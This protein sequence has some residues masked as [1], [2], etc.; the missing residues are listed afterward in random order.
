LR[1]LQLRLTLLAGHNQLRLE[2]G[3]WV[4][5]GSPDFG[6]NPTIVDHTSGSANNYTWVDQSVTDAGVILQSPI[7]DATALTTPYLSF[8]IMSH[9]N[10]GSVTTFNEIH[11]EASDGVGGWVPVDVISGD[12]GFQ[13]VEFGY[14]V[15]GLTYGANLLQF[16]FRAESGGDS[17]DYDNDMLLD[18]VGVSEMPTCP[19]P[20]GLAAYNFTST[21]ADFD[22]TENGT[23]T[24]WFIEYGPVGFT[25][26][27]GTSVA[28]G[29]NTG[30]NLTGLT[31]NTFYEGYVRSF[32]SVGDTSAYHGPVSFNTYDVAPFTFMGWDN[33]C[34]TLGF[35][36]IS[37]TGTDLG[38]TDDG[39]AGVTLDY[40]FIYQGTIITEMTVGNN[41][42]IDLGTLTGAVGYGG[43][44]NTLDDGIH[45]WGDDLDEE[46]G[47][48]YY[49]VVGTAPNRITIVQWDNI[50]NFSG[51]IGD[52]TVTFQVQIFETTNEI[53]F[54]YD[55]VV[56]GGTDAA[57]DYAA[58][59]D[60]GAAGPVTD[61]NISNNDPTFLTNNSCVRFYYP[62]CPAPTAL[63][64]VG[65]ADNDSI[66]FSWAAG[67]TETEWLI[68]YGPEGFTPGTGTT[69]T[70]FTTQ[71]TIGG[72]SGLTTYDIYVQA[73][74]AV[75]DSSTFHGPLSASTE[76]NPLNCVASTATTLLVEDFEGAF[77]A[78]WSQVATADPDWTWDG[79]GGTGSTNTGPSGA[80]SGTGFLYLETSGGA[81]G[82]TDTLFAPSVNLTSTVGDARA[83]WKYHMYGDD[84]GK[85]GFEVSTDGVLW[86]EVWSDSGQLQLDELD[87]W[88]TASA[89]LTPYA[90][91]IVQMRFVG[92][93]AGTFNGDMAI[94]TFAVEA[95]ISCQQPTGLAVSN[96]T[97]NTVDLIW[98]PGGLESS[99]IIEYGPAGFTP[100]TGTQVTTGNNPE[101]VTG[102][103]DNTNY[104]FYVYA[105][106]GGGDISIPDGP[107]NTN[108]LIA[109]PAPSGLTITYGSND[110]VA[111]TWTPGGLEAAWIIE[112]G[113][114]GFTPGTGTAQGSTN[115]PDTITGLA[116]GVYEFYVQAD[117][118]SGVNNPWDG[119]VVYATPI[120]NDSTCNSINVPVDGSTTNYVN[121]NGTT[122]VGETTAGF[123][124]VWFDFIAPASGHVE[125]RTCGTDFDNMLEVFTTTDCSDFGTFT[126]IVATNSNPFTTCNGVDP[127]GVNLCGLTPGAKYYLAIGSEVDGVTGIFPLTLTEL[128]AINAGTATPA[129]AC[130]A[131][132]AFDLFNSISG[133]LTTTG[134]WYNPTVAPGN[135]IPSTI[136]A[137][138]VPVGTYPMFYV[139]EEICGSDTVETSITVVAAPNV[140]TGSTV[141]AGCNFN[142]VALT[143]GLSGTI[144]LGG[145]WYDDA[146]NPLTG[147]LVTF[148]GEPA[149]NY[150]YH[151]VVDN[152]VC[153]ADS[154]TV[155]VTIIDCVGLEENNLVMNVYPNPVHDQLNIQM[156]NYT[157]TTTI[158]VYDLAGKRMN[159]VYTVSGNIIKLDVEDYADGVYLLKLTS[160]G[161]T[162]EIRVVK[163]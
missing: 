54:V 133:N 109:C 65:A 41:G 97:I 112:Y 87:P 71:D 132:A 114:L 26:G 11:V 119:P 3:P 30:F 110:T 75:G 130:E 145:T 152:G 49:E 100:G 1:R 135:E 107:V 137:V 90:G 68:E 37:G 153:A 20:N 61:F 118:G 124:T 80:Y 102:L 13:W 149:G 116:P 73:V 159:G 94:D 82:D 144:D 148:N 10:S 126:S 15:S 59:A 99:W 157:A 23:A 16:R 35:Q 51:A 136:S 131:D 24:A 106:C 5:T 55:D 83:T 8:W 140:G 147:S 27:T 40:P 101:T 129:D 69:F 81:A 72:L 9:N 105:D 104:D 113:P 44:M 123:N 43:D 156:T 67:N 151:Y 19:T 36:D 28:A 6:T 84:M 111:F 98:T 92:T 117:C 163:Q 103:I 42:G 78:D 127:A 150:D 96:E 62:T 79:A 146:G 115:I 56:F 60:I 45:P 162:Q 139:H 134:T 77:P 32:C 74:C 66:I 18:D 33:S 39:E 155:T 85:M 161:I 70:T 64:V 47:N 142:S 7:I 128:P 95:C 14:N 31:P 121:I 57:D 21:T 52:P 22:W 29:T 141:D 158:E 46:T 93:S 125:I 120:T 4:Y 160:E 138:G 2:G 122:Q 89:D 143:D 58:N 48:V 53:F 63:S 25:P 91:N 76:I 50:C 34:P 154:S 108:T 17:F 12:F 38:L 86:T 88:A